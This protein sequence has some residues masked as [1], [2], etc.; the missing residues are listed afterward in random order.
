MKYLHVTM[1]FKVTMFFVAEF[2]LNPG[3]IHGSTVQELEQ[4][5][6]EKAALEKRL[7]KAFRWFLAP[8]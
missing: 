6:S 4:A 1:L 3:G 7:K 5:L 2:M 8:K